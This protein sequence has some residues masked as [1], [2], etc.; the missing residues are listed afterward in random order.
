MK[1]YG[2]NSLIGNAGEMFLGYHV[3]NSLNY[4]YRAQP[5]A[6][7]GIDGEIEL[8]YHESAATGKIV[9][10]QVKT[11]S[12]ELDKWDWKVNVLKKDIVYWKLLSIPV[13]LVAVV[14]GS[15]KCYYR[16]IDYTI[17]LQNN[18]SASMDINF[19]EK[20]VDMQDILLSRSELSK[21]EYANTG[22]KIVLD[23][24]YSLLYR[25]HQIPQ[26]GD[27]SDY[28]WMTIII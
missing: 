23:H 26:Y 20:F 10:V 3:A 8:L 25:A 16:L 6:D 24:M 15:R 11:T 18:D 17:I 4:I 14:L 27:L 5:V 19:S 1:M 13:I 9:K 7:I 2:R 28:L 12:V 22:D 21:L